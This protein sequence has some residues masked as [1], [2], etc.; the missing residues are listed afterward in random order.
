MK[1]IRKNFLWN[2]IG[3]SLSAVSSLVFLIVVTRINGLDDAGIFSYAFA[4]A[5]VFYTISVY[6][7]RPYQ[8]TD[9]NKMNDSDFIYNRIIT[10]I[11]SIVC[12][13]GFSFFKGYTSY[14]IIV[15]LLCLIYKCVE[16]YSECYYA[17]LQKNDELYKVGISY[18][19]KSLLSYLLFLIMD[20]V[21][22]NIILSLLFIIVA[23]IIIT[24]IY[25]RNKA[26][27]N[28]LSISSFNN[29][30]NMELLKNGFYVCLLGFLMIYLLNCSRYSIDNLMPNSSQ[31]IY[32]IVFMPAMVMSLLSQF[33]IHPFL[34][35]LK[36]Y[37]YEGEY[38]K[39][40]TLILKLFGVYIIISLIIVLV[41]AFIGIPI[42]ELL[43]GIKLKEYNTHLVLIM[44]SSCMYGITVMSS[45]ILISM[46][47]LKLQTFAFLVVFIISLFTSNYFVSRYGLMGACYNNLVIQGI[48]ATILCSLIVFVK[49][50][51]CNN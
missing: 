33:F 14:K 36:D 10:I 51:K 21:T 28:N 2:I 19:L 50:D 11:F 49:K 1:N 48:I 44:L 26:K 25:D 4:T 45:Y 39:F 15:L 23:N 24:I 35:S 16:A 8:V 3:S 12:L 42:L 31:T 22:K 47:K 38:K 6:I 30:R 7:G 13:L 9:N 18:T 34:N 32:G 37:F 29:K 43:Y 20:M 5:C 46:R 27:E 41:S 40:H 17:I